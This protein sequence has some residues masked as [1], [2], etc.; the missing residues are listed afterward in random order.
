VVYLV[1]SAQLGGTEASVL[2]MIGSFRDAHSPWT[3]RVIAPDEGPLVER[4][5]A[6]G[7]PVTVLPFP[8]ALARLGEAGRM[9]TAAGRARFA[10]E[11]L[12]ALLPA[13]LYGRRLKRTLASCGPIAVVHAHGF[14]MQV[15][16][17]RSLPPG[18]SLVWHAHDYVSPR[19][20][21]AKL[22]RRFAPRCSIVVANSM[23]VAADVRRVCGPGLLVAV[24]Y[25]AVDLRRFAPEGPALDLDALGRAAP[26]PAQ[27]VRVGLLATFGRW[28]GHE[29]FLRALAALPPRLAIRGYII[30]GAQYG[31]AASQ[32][33]EES[34]RR[35]AA[36]LG[37]TDRVVFTGAVND[38][39][40]ALRALD[41]VVHA[42][43]EPEP[44]GMV[45]AEAMACGRPVI[46][47]LAG[48]A[49][50]LVEDG[51]DALGHAPASVPELAA[52]LTQLA[53]DRALR[54]RLGTAARRSAEQRFDRSR[55]AIELTSVYAALPG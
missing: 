1:S 21:S 4:L 10:L 30:G 11:F 47:S 9:S 49:A 35:V 28:K 39:A 16:G 15:L 32:A 50:E 7:T 44:F 13:A 41:V 40:G 48:G 43:T 18:A 36:D 42:S 54:E 26:A 51:V 38:A 14:K 33:T 19:R 5:R 27:T 20:A 2:E 6:S 31:T 55:L 34:L 45:I 17:A 12:R 25:N 24:M 52:R 37:L 23:S 8:A 3:F 46:V 22:L 53:G 29:V